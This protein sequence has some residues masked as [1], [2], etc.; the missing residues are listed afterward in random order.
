MLDV[1]DDLLGKEL[2]LDGMELPASLCQSL[3]I[4]TDAFGVEIC[5]GLLDVLELISKDI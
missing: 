1:V 4:G 3:G 5:N 2:A